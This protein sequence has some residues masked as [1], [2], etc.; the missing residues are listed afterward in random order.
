MRDTH[1]LQLRLFHLGRGVCPQQVQ[2]QQLAKVLGRSP[3]A[4]AQVGL[5][6]REE[7]G[8]ARKG[9]GRETDSGEAES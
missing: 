8:Q 6:G 9:G 7:G 4:T 1:L 2:L 5:R 3:Q